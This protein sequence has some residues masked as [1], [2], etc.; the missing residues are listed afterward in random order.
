MG[1]D[2]SHVAPAC[3]TKIL[4]N[5]CGTEKFPLSSSWYRGSSPFPAD[6]TNMC[7][8]SRTPHIAMSTSSR[9]RRCRSPAPIAAHTAATAMNPRPHATSTTL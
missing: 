8:D 7:Q 9:T 1:M 4:R 3:M 5:T 2:T 6:F